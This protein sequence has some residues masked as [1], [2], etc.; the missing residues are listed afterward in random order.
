MFTEFC[1]DLGLY[2]SDFSFFGG[3]PWSASSSPDSAASISRSDLHD[4]SARPLIRSSSAVF[5]NDV[6]S[7]YAQ[8]ELDRNL[9]SKQQYVIKFFFYYT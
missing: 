7:D 8:T 6:N 4:T 5:S 9:L 1:I 2:G 3:G